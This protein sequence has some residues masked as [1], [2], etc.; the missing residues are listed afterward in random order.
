MNRRKEIL[1]EL[2]DAAPA[3]AEMDLQHPYRVPGGYFESLPGLIMF[4]IRLEN[5]ESVQD[6][7][8]I[9]SPLLNSLNKNMPFSTPDGYFDTL[10]PGIRVAKEEVQ[11]PARVVKM[12]QPQKT[13]RL[14]AAAVTI[15]VIGIAAWMFMREPATDLYATKSDSEVQKELKNKVGELSENE[16]THFIEGS[17]LITSY[18]STSLEEINED[19]VKLMLADIPDQELEKF[20]DQHSVKEK[21]N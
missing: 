3:L 19:D 8:E 4:R 20:I 16:L 15:G 14:A 10:T 9:I 21:F 12:F 6:E 5:V 1:N 7:L 18:D 17:T 11:K 2:K 13:F